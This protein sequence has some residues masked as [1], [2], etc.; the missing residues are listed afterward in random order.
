MR[1][2]RWWQK[3]MVGVSLGV[4]AFLYLPIVMLVM[5]SFN[6]SKVT[7]F[8]LAGFTLHWYEAFLANGTMLRA[9]WNSLVV[10]VFA[11]ALSVA[12]GV[13]AALAL[14]RYE[15]P[16]KRL[17]QNAILLP[18]SLP[19][20]VTGIAML[21]F[22]KQIGIPQSLTAVVIG[23]ATALL[24]VVVSQVMTRLAKINRRQFEASADLGAT[25]VETFRRVTLP[26]IRSSIIGSALLCF[27]LSF[28]EIP[29]TYFLTGR[30][31]TLPIYIY[32]TLRRGITPEINAIGT[33]IV[34]ASFILIIL[35]VT[36]LR[37][38]DQS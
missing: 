5:F 22:Y 25:P 19:G 14:D 15:F 37:E 10:A 18:L 35:S 6:D 3:G 38:R 13:T 33:V 23:H 8:P 16:G 4:L 30:E 36:L 24:G 20:I 1:S 12:I 29:V 34:A 2:L 28:D 31:V 9:F 26:S 11:T 17:F 27:T 32:S 7:S 21:N